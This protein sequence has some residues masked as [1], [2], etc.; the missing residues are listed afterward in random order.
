MNAEQMLER[1]AALRRERTRLFWDLDE[2]KKA[3]KASEAH[4]DM[5]LAKAAYDSVCED[6]EMAL[7]EACE[8]YRQP[9]LDMGEV[10]DEAAEIINGGALDTDA[11]TCSAEVHRHDG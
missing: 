5:Q 7:G 11:V 4:R 3:L 10:L 8:S 9:R 1:I 2:K 6:L